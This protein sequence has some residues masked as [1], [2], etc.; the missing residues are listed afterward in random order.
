MFE[1]FTRDASD[2]VKRSRDEAARLRSPTVDA[3]H[4]LLALTAPASGPPA[5][6]LAEA[7]LDRAGLI[8][9]F[10]TELE[11]TLDAIGVPAAALLE[12]APPSGWRSPRFGQSAKLALTRSLKV[13]TT[14]RD[15]RLAPAH[16]LLGVLRA[17]T[18]TVP[19]ALRGTGVE[20]SELADRMAAAMG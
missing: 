15:R 2:V 11:S 4:L 17:E 10:D 16:I 6:V 20:P 5:T 14:R 19:R 13:A 18:G 7:G 8:A 3:L 12:Q 9:A 1:R